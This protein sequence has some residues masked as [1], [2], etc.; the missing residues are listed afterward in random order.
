MLFVY[1]IVC[2]IFINLGKVWVR[3]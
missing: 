1:H 3:K 2:V